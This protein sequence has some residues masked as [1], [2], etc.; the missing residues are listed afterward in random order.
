MELAEEF[1]RQR[2]ER[3]REERWLALFCAV[4]AAVLL[5]V[6]AAAALDRDA[7]GAPT[8]FSR[9]ATADPRYFTTWSSI[10]FVAGL[11]VFAALPW[12][13]GG[14]RD[15]SSSSWTSWTRAVLRDLARCAMVNAVVVG[16]LGPFV[17][18]YRSR[19]VPGRACGVVLRSNFW[20]HA[21][22]AL[23]ATIVLVR[24]ARTAPP[25]GWRAVAL[26]LAFQLAY[27]WVPFAR[28]VGVD[29]LRAVYAQDSLAA[30]LGVIATTAAL[31]I[32]VARTLSER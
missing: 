8:R 30:L 18:A 27:L 26:T 2:D 13:P 4:V 11:L 28:V 24:V 6:A 12:W 31:T 5:A 29:K 16:A 9:H 21:L 19:P 23:I 20:Q 15:A 25:L 32:V 14:A 17:I 7:D 10:A 3:T 1:S 22:P